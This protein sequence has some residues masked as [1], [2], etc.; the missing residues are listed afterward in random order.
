MHLFRANSHTVLLECG[1][2]RGPRE[3]SRRRNG[4]FPFHPSQIDSVVISHA[5][6]DHCGNLPTLVK[7]GF[8]GPVYCTP[9]TR[10][11][12]HAILKD[13]ARIQEEDA[14]H[15]AMSR[16]Y[17]EPLPEPL[18]T[19]VDA[20]RAIDLCRVVA[21]ETPR[22][23]FPG[24]E[25]RF[26]DAGHILGSASVHLRVTLDD[27]GEQSL[28]FTGDLGRCHLPFLR[29]PAPIPPADVIICE[30]TYGGRVHEPMED[31]VRKLEEATHRTLTRGGKVLVPAFSLGRTQLV[32]HYLR[33]GM[34]E[35]RLP[36]FPIYV[37]SP[38]ATDIAEVYRDYPD[39]LD[40]TAVFGPHEADFLGS[41][42]VRYVR[43]F[44]ESQQLS[45]RP[46]P[47][48]LVASSGMCEA[49]RIVNHLKRNV[50]DPRNTI[51][52]VSFQ[53]PGTV[54]R[55][56][57]EKSPTVRFLGK[58]WNKWADVVHL[59]G[60]SGHADRHDFETLLGPLVGR[61]KRIRLIHGEREQAESLAKTLRGLGFADVSIPEAGETVSL[62]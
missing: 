57:L 28:T 37:D 30:S 4:Q 32:V 58:D 17:S 42:A 25:M 48:I 1:L 43:N 35:G 61:A 51:I 23:I 19:R 39:A 2:F 16:G 15:L 47:C 22:M 27:G 52:L 50:D 11:L 10:D 40:E 54:G 41:D 46:G 8:H 53:A 49:G 62:A 9:A 36:R 5:H 60:F 12:M 34:R 20:E 18:Y 38:L 29:P 14:A 55:R 33:R 31:T 56:L 13:S 24:V 6:V 3:E 26:T 44:E 45:T 59:D 7:Q 21:Y